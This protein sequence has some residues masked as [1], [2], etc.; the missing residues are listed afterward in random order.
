MEADRPAKRILV[1]S[2]LPY[3]NGPIHIGHLVE[4]IQTDIHV[5]FL[6]LLG[7]DVIYCCA[8]DTHG[9]PISIK[10]EQ[11]GI[12]PEEL[13]AQTQKEHLEDFSS[14]H[15]SFDSYYSTNSAE[16]QEYANKIFGELKQKGLIYQKEVE[17]FYDEKEHRFLPDRYVKGECPKCGAKDQYGDVCEACGSTHKPTDLIN[18]YSVLSKTK[19]IRKKSMH[20]FFRLS[21]LSEKL[22]HWL[23]GNSKLQP[24]IVNY[25]GN[26]IK[27]GLQDW[28]ISRDGPYFGFRIP[29]EDD[30]Y[31]YVWL[32]APIG[33]IS[34]TQHWC[35]QHGLDAEEHYWK[36]RDSRIIHFIGKDIMYFHFLFWPA[37][38]MES[39]FNLPDNLVVHGFLTVNGEKM[40]KSRG[41][42]LTAKDFLRRA[43]PEFL[44]Y[45]YAG[46]LSHSINDIDLNFQDLQERINT[47]LVANVANFFYR[48]LSFTHQNFQGTT[49]KVKDTKT[50][51]AWSALF[52]Q[53]KEAFQSFEYREAVKRIMHLSTL[54]NR[55]FQ[56][57]EPW[58][59]I[60]EDREE[61]LSVLT[62]CVNLVKDLTISLKPI[63]PVF[64]AA[65]EKQLNLK[66]LTWKDL[67]FRLEGHRLGTPK[68]IL[69]P[70]EIIFDDIKEDKKDKQDKKDRQDK[71]HSQDKKHK[72]DKTD[73][74]S[75]DFGLLNLK[76]AE[77]LEAKEH[78]DADRLLVLQ[79]D[80][81][82]EQRQL[83]AGIRK[84]YRPEELVGRHI[85]IVANLKEATLRGKKSQGM[86]LAGQEGEKLVLVEAPKSRPGDQ[87]TVPGI[88]PNQEEITIDDFST[89]KILALD[90]RVLWD[91][92]ELRT[93]TE[94]L[95]CQGIA[96][97]RIG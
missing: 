32:D 63:L 95:R 84:H 60:K 46:N 15:I 19:P 61:T 92:K 37:M 16:N 81:G 64:T 38:L 39:G 78:P 43:D 11:L 55:Y 3:A 69:R 4:Y 18:P 41:T 77:V 6:R 96:R 9:T 65:I 62:L 89:V 31:F 13:I 87:V 76:V 22:D 17:N 67:D 93:G 71:K 68:I 35:R 79:I 26:W 91:G 59:L 5:R 42:F 45:Y 47:E 20:Y 90:G 83:V 97:S 27:E 33:Y 21:A 2:A 12:R 24:E 28:D 30:K 52:G 23:R 7:K 57:K 49:G 86:L 53:V 70:T 29:G 73:D 82:E 1:T 94:P 80:L 36:S 66:E 50:A 34:S 44:R 56:E 85:V 25:V 75:G 10:A 14:F 51:T 48:V 88:T 54:G 72:Q 40:S 58:K 74:A 8:D